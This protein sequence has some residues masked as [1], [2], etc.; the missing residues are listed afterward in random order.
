[1]DYRRDW[2]ESAPEF[3][4]TRAEEVD[5]SDKSLTVQ[6]VYV[7]A[8]PDTDVDISLLAQVQGNPAPSVRSVSTLPSW[9]TRQGTHITGRTPTDFSEEVV[10]DVTVQ[11]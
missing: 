11:N 5:R 4:S 7:Y 2:V 1:M 3:G 8:A 9:L 6:T 10:I